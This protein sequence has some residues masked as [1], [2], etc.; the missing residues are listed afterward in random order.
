MSIILLLKIRDHSSVSTLNL[1]PLNC[2]RNILP[3]GKNFCKSTWRLFR[4]HT[5]SL[6]LD[7]QPCCP[8]TCTASLSVL[9]RSS[10]ATIHTT[11]CPWAYTVFNPSSHNLPAY[12]H[13]LSKW[14]TSLLPFSNNI[15]GVPIHLPNMIK[16]L[17]ISTSG[18]P[19]RM[20][21][22]SPWMTCTCLRIECP[23]KRC[24]PLV[25]PLCT[26]WRIIG[27]ATW[28]LWSG[29]M[30]CGWMRA[31]LSTLATFVYKRLNQISKHLIT[32]QPCFP[33]TSEKVGAT[34]RMN[35]SRPIQSLVRS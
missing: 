27:S 25:I 19:W 30:T 15:S 10:F 33:F 26:N 32:N 24:S 8:L 3:W 7:R 4:T 12:V 21:V 28:S 17:R 9:I 23:M 31:L 11:T 34:M 6:R 5:S 20:L 29:G 16:Y 1:C 18:V 14:Q 2:L 35:W 22:L 13:I